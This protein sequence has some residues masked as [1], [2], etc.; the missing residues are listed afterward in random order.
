MQEITSWFPEVFQV[1]DLLV[2]IKAAHVVFL[3]VA[4]GPGASLHIVDLAAGPGAGAGAD[5]GVGAAG[6]CYTGDSGSLRGRLSWGFMLFL[7]SSLRLCPN[8]SSP[9]FVALHLVII[10]TALRVLRG[11]YDNV[12]EGSA[13]SKALLLSHLP[14]VDWCKR[15]HV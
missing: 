15:R 5:A 14:S 8:C 10:A 3:A 6:T 4:A 2:V 7:D 12:P 1:V 9:L 13:G 11:P